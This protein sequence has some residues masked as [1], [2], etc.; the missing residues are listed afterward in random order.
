M[1]E[2]STLLDRHVDFDPAGDFEAFL[3]S[4][5]SK[6]VVYLFCDA[7]NRPV[8]LLC[9]KNLR[10]SLKRRLGGDEQVGP[11]RRVNYRDLVRHIHYRRVDSAFEADW[12]YYEAARDLFPQSYQ[13]MVGFRP[14]W[15]IH[16]NPESQF[17]RYI[18]T[19]DLSRPGLH[20]GPVEDKHVAAR[21]IQL[22]EDLFDLC[23][24][25][26]LLV[27]SPNAKACAYKEMGKCPAPCDGTISMEQY[28]HVIEWSART[29]V[30]PADF[31]RM[32]T[33]RMQHA[34]SEL[35][36]E[37]A[38]KIKAYVEQLSQLGKGPFRF[39]RLLKDF[40]FVSFQHGPRPATIKVFLIGPGSIREIVCMIDEPRWPAEVLGLVLQAAEAAARERLARQA[41]PRV[42]L[43]GNE[44]DRPAVVGI[45]PQPA[46][47]ASR[48]Q[49]ADSVG[50]VGAERIG[51]VA[52]HLFSAKAGH[53]VFIRLDGLDEKAIVRAYRDLLKRPA[54][55]ELEAE[56]VMKELQSL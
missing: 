45:A 52:H 43:A 7:D 34:A 2:I 1:P 12:L 54:E 6:W 44:F 42:G 16:V 8:Q 40:Q 37:T 18:K 15:F 17:P 50:L 39:A 32:H 33:A 56:G 36:F 27:E 11:S 29:L 48:E 19:T 24:Y 25:Y 21:L 3:R 26:N 46:P 20:I 5:P 9:V 23:R 28:R 22:V 10:A 49:T 47:P 35:Q 4:A 38:G 51:I 41:D 30:D 14:A 53:G 13:G 31:I 55:E